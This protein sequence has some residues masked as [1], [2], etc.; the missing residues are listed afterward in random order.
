MQILAG[1]LIF[2]LLIYTGFI[3]R[4]AWVFAHIKC[5]RGL[6]LEKIP[7]VSVIIPARNEE[8]NIATCLDLV[9]KQ[10]YPQDKYEIIL[11]DDHSTDATRG[12]ALVKAQKYQNLSVLSLKDEEQNSFKKAA[13]TAG[14]RMARGEIILQTDADCMVGKNWIT[15]MVSH[16]APNTALVTGPV[17]LTYRPRNF[18]I[19]QM[20]ESMG[21]VA[22]GAGSLTDRRPNMCNGA[23][24]AYRK[25]VFEE[26]GGFSGVDHVASGDDEL[27]LQKIHLLGRYEMRFARCEET[28]VRTPALMHWQEFRQQRL[29]WVSKARAYKNRRVNLIQMIS[30]LGF[31]SFPVLLI[32]SFADW[33]WLWALTGIFILKLLADYF[34]LYQAAKFFHKLQMLPYVIPLQFVYIPY[35]LWIG[36][37]GNLV[38]TYT[39]KGRKV[40]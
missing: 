30:W 34:L 29:R 32:L 18:E 40:K 5:E 38:R 26:V 14:I 7:F 2:C 20:L 37:A 3:L 35:V 6:Q 11:V 39:W 28:I 16:F 8:Q 21:L 36:V 12:I 25:D 13:I 10:T 1:I 15:G 17:R 4:N 31:A 27:L 19:F 24:L 22:I 23:N 9:L 33:T